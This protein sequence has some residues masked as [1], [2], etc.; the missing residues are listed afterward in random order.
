M[1]IYKIVEKED[2]LLRERS[3]EVPKITANVIKLLDNMLDTMYKANGVGLAAPQIGVL[4]RCIVVDVGEGPVKLI[5]PEITAY[6]GTQNGPEG[7]L[8]CPGLVGDVKRAKKITVKGLLPSG[9]ETIIEAEDYFARALQHEIDHLDG[10]LFID[11][12]K[13]LEIQQ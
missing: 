5:N 7:C 8:S 10:I 11:K 13:H 4:K 2:E 1:A 12:A 9:E 6:S 3:K